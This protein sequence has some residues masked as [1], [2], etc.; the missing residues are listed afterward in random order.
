[1]KIL[2]AA[3][4]MVLTSLWV[5]A[6]SVPTRSAFVEI[7]GP[8]LVY[9]FNYDF[10]FDKQDL[11]SWGLRV[12]AGGYKLSEEALLTVPVQVTRL[13][14]NGRNYFEVGAGFTFINYTDTYTHYDYS[15]YDPNTGES[16]II[17]RTTDKNYHF[18]LDMGDTPAIVGTLNIG[19]RRIPENGGFTFRTNITPLF[20]AYGFWPLFAGVGLGYAF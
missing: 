13:L 19:Y 2:F 15:N 12:G 18:I 6:Q 9:S 14:G 17:G 16:P 8:S 20:N 1:M 5:Q 3:A 4:C 11:N 7:G 10:R